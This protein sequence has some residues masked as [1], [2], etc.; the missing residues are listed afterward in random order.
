MES[1]TEDVTQRVYDLVRL[2]QE[3]TSLEVKNLSAQVK[4]PKKQLEKAKD[5]LDEHEQYSRR[6]LPVILWTARGSAGK[7]GRRHLRF[8]E[9]RI[10][11]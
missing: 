3:K 1:I 7:Y 2:D 8:R 9:E 11:N 4:D 5:E 10:G 6:K